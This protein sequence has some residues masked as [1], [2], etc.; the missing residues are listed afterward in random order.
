[1]KLQNLSAAPHL[2]A[3]IRQLAGSRHCVWDCL[4]P[5]LPIQTGNLSR[6][7]SHFVERASLGKP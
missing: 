6:V 1:M 5:K 3:V 7:L 4:Q 2:D